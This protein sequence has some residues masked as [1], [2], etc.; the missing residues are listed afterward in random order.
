MGDP[1][2]AL[3]SDRI[4]PD[5]T[6]ALVTGTPVAA[7]PLSYL[8][9]GWPHTVFRTASAAP[10]RI[11]GDRGASGAF[12]LAAFFNAN[13]DAALAMAIATASNAA[14]STGVTSD[15]VT[16]PA[17][18]ADGR[19]V[20]PF[21]DLSARSNRYFR[22][23]VTG[24][25]SVAPA[26]GEWWLTSAKR[27]LAPVSAMRYGMTTHK[28]RPAKVHE[29]EAGPAAPIDYGV[30]RRFITGEFRTSAAGVAQLDALWEAVKGPV[31]P[32]LWIPDSDVNEAWLVRF[33][34][35]FDVT[36]IEATDD[37]GEWVDVAVTFDEVS[38][39]VPV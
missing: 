19:R 33:V 29:T 23:D 14:F 2:Y 7:N 1:C 24:T 15:A 21:V 16:V 25:N 31:L 36:P 22:L 17:T 5:A 30:T 20:A 10:F 38:A 18:R 35:D 8:Y 12:G 9:D 34:S 27:V 3:P 4:L 11:D 32:F 39:G 28:R 6:L 26:M 13:F 37:D